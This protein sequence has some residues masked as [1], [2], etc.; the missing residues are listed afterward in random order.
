MGAGKVLFR[1]RKIN[2]LV[3]V[4]RKL[5]CGVRGFSVLRIR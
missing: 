3:C 2:K 4:C 5:N 1:L